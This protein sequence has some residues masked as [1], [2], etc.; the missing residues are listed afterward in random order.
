MLS[1]T[2]RTQVKKGVHKVCKDESK[3]YEIIDE[4]LL[5]HVAIVENRVPIVIP[6]L[7][8]RVKNDV[9]VHGANNS[10]LLKTLKRGV[11]TSLT[12]TL[13]DGWVLARSAMHHSAHYRSAVVFGV[14]D[15]VDEN[16]EKSRILNHF[17]EQI[18]PNRTDEIRL[19]NE[20]ELAATLLLKIPLTEASVKIGNQGVNDDLSDMNRPVWA[21]ILPYKTIVGPLESV[22]DLMDSIETPD[23]SVAYGE[24]WHDRYKR[25]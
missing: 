19:G 18:S 16:K 13:F 11:E 23:Y 9:Y 7:A 10:R 14:F 21:G 2:E 6:M 5:A 3:L 17:I 25:V 20:K 15:V 22:D 24:R 8:W 1:N 4:S 12:F